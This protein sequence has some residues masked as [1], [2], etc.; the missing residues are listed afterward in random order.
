MFHIYHHNRPNR[1]PPVHPY[2]PPLRSAS[3]AQLQGVGSQCRSKHEGTCQR[4]LSESS[5]RSKHEAVKRSPKILSFKVRIV[6]R[7]HAFSAAGDVNI[8]SSD[9]IIARDLPYLRCEL[10]LLRE[11]TDYPNGNERN[12][13]IQVRSTTL[14]N[15]PLP[16]PDSSHCFTALEFYSVQGL[17]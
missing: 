17:S 4:G 9:A 10:P 8:Q 5:T 3:F 6:V 1:H 13:N 16:P 12:P 14:P 2:S 11:S 7:F 15:Q